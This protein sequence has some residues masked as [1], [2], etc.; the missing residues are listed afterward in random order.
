MRFASWLA[1]ATL[2]VP[3]GVAGCGDEDG[4][5]VDS[6][7]DDDDSTSACGAFQLVGDGLPSALLSIWGTSARDLYMVG[8][9]DGN[10]PL[11]IHFDGSAWERLDTSGVPGDLWW[12]WGDAQDTV[13]MSGAGGRVVRYTPTTG[14]FTQ[15]IVAD[16]SFTLFGIWGSAPTDVWAVAADVGRTREGELLHFDG[17]TWRT[18]TTIPETT[19]KR[20]PFKVWGTG[21]DDIWFVGT[22]ALLT[23]WDG[24]S[25]TDFAAPINGSITLFT[26]HG[27]GPTDVWA[28]GGQ[29][30][31]AVVRWDGTSWTNDSPPPEAIAPGFTGVFVDTTLGPVVAGNN[32]AIWTRTEAGWAADCRTP[33]T[34]WN[35]HAAFVDPDGGIWASGGDLI[36]LDYGVVTYGGDGSIPSADGT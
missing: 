11:V 32:G 20:Q 29:G 4:G 3:C 17:T 5:T 25:F 19:G 31:G 9:D 33:A 14:T 7:G 24:A 16:P 8:P 34:T 10:G 12:V 36:N 18:A 27:T 15:E 6:T 21:P 26:V 35:F 28:V 1:I 23:H 2:I 13:W 22:E 30:N